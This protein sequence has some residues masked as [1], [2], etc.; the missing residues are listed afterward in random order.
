MNDE[1]VTLVRY[2]LMGHVGRFAGTLPGEPATG[3]ERGQL[4]VIRSGRGEELGEV[5]LHVPSASCERKPW[6]QSR[7]A[8]AAA[9]STLLADDWAD[10][11]RLVRAALSEDLE[12]SRQAERLRG[13]RFDLCRQILGE[14]R[15]PLELL[16]VEPLLDLDTTVLHLLGPSGLDLLRAEFRGRC[17]FRVVFEYLTSCTGSPLGGATEPYSAPARGR[18]E[19]CDC[20]DGFAPACQD[21]VSDAEKETRARSS[22]APLA[23]CGDQAH[24]RCEVCEIEKWLAGTR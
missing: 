8:S 11:P 20:A 7:D 17:D 18:C 10:R 14:G 9:L 23:C 15:W 16:D 4:V 13:E 12:N 24:T 6:Q 5:L 21:C 19:C 22:S 1:P 3:P 2:G